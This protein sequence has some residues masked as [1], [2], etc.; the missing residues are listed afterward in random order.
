[1]RFIKLIAVATFAL[2]VGAC[3]GG[4]NT[5][6][7]IK[8][9]IDATP[10]T[11]ALPLLVTFKAVLSNY[12]GDTE[13]LSY[14]WDFGDG[15][16][17]TS[18]EPS[19][20]YEE[21]GT[22]TVKITVKDGDLK[23]TA[24]TE[25]VVGPIGPGVDL[26]VDD[27]VV[28]P[29]TINPGG[30]VTVKVTATNAGTDAA[31]GT[32]IVRVFILTNETWPGSVPS[33]SGVINISGI[34]GGETVE[35]AGSAYVPTSATAGPYYVYAY[36][37]GPDPNS[38]TETNEDNNVTRSELPLSVTSGTLPIDITVDSIS[39]D[40]TGAISPGSD[41]TVTATLGNNGTQ[42]SSSFKVAFR[43]SVDPVIDPAGDQPLGMLVNV[44]S[45]P[46]GGT[47]DIS[48]TFT[49]AAGL[50]N[51]PYYLGVLGDVNGDVA[52]T[53]EDN[54]IGVSTE[55]VQVT[56]S[57]GC[58]EDAMEPN[59]V[60]ADAPTLTEGEHAGLMVC[61]NSMEW[62]AIDLLAGDRLTA[63]TTFNNGDGNIDMEL[64]EEGNM[65]PVSASAGTG[66][67]EVVS[68]G[69]ATE[70]KTYY[71]ALSVG[72]TTNGAPYTLDLA[73]AHSGGNG[74]DLV[75]ANV[76]V[77]PT[78]VAAGT[79]VN[80]S[81]DVYNFGD[82]D[83]SAD[84]MTR[85]YLSEDAVVDGAD[86]V[87]GETM[88]N[89]I[90][91]GSSSAVMLT[92]T[93]PFDTAPNNYY[94]II[95]VDADDAVAETYEDNNDTIKPIA[96]G[97][98]CAEDSFED[99]D[100][101][102]SAATLSTG[103]YN[104]RLCPNDDDWFAFEV[105][106]GAT[107]TFNIGF[108]DAL[109]DI[110]MRLYDA[111]QNQLDSSASTGNSEE[112]TYTNGSGST[113]TY[114]ARVYYYSSSPDEEG[115]DVSLDVSGAVATTVDLS[116][117]TVTI[118]PGTVYEGDGVNVTFDMQN[119]SVEDAA[120]FDVDLRLSVDQNIDG[121]DQTLRTVNVNGLL[122]GESM[123]LTRK[124]T[125]PAGMGGT[126]YVGAFMDSANAMVEASET[127][128]GRASTQK[129]TVLVPCADDGYEDNDTSA[130]AAA[131][132][133]GDV[134]NGLV[135][136]TGDVDWFEV[137]AGSTGP[138]TVHM[139]FVH[140]DGDLDMK[141]YENDGVTLLG[142]SAGVSDSEEIVVD[143]TAGSTYKVYVKG[144]NGAANDYSLQTSQ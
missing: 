105:Q 99:N 80:V 139:D 37:D 137:T 142:S 117:G 141:V 138:L 94:V 126:W 41:F 63:T 4:L 78:S 34:Q 61:P 96:V 84:S 134:N 118:T 71:V 104:A 121:G 23:G 43:L 116:V 12:D 125:I 27:V 136:C 15:E 102:M 81:Y 51:R 46:A 53:D 28:T 91:S 82:T 54:N 90:T 79:N 62:F 9:Q 21:E 57:S 14:N 144:F 143:A 101:A 93:V 119:L 113:E 67:T 72:S 86:V 95:S 26:R 10:D 7:G 123:E 76:N 49:L 6:D 120:A 33:A 17:S 19:H 110:D 18:A 64:Y 128:N 45:I 87:L 106:D 20:T 59:E 66:N 75:A 133:L 50:D 56:G 77:A 68:S 32:V 131:I 39:T 3:G 55:L 1:M 40:L 89:A 24:T 98:G 44:P 129:L 97:I 132:N 22:Y 111:S 2:M 74:R 107:L 92:G 69:L 124:I 103:Q 29:N 11:G 52:E 16:S 112:V 83:I 70:A 73:L 127:N 31:T 88:I 5:T 25:I 130:Q 8:V 36:I 38:V 13:A 122:A 65:T 100:D 85:V 42:D 30:A 60:L 115:S 108:D 48:E 58:T 140:A 114:Y 47:T 135:I 109:G 35:V